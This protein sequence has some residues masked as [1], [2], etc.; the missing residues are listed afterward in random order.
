VSE[1][2]QNSKF[3][4]RTAQREFERGVEQHRVCGLLARRQFGKTTIAGRI[5]L[6]NPRAHRDLW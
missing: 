3:K 6:K 2:V 5:A 1:P 4:I